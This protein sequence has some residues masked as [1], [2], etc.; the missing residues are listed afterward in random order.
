MVN[1]SRD[2][3][4][5]LDYEMDYAGVVQSAFKMHMCFFVRFFHSHCFFFSRNIQKA[6]LSAFFLK[7][8]LF[9]FKIV[10]VY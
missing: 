3:E 4:H 5:E 8:V 1:Y 9:F 2:V 7:N 10:L 6:L